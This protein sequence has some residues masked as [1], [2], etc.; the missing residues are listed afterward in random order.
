LTAVLTEL[1]RVERTLRE[2]E[3]LDRAILRCFKRRHRAMY[4]VDIAAAV[5]ARIPLVASRLRAL[6]RRGLLTSVVVSV[7]GPT[8]KV[9]ERRYYRLAEGA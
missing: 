9:T 3:Q 5:K 4:S 6:Q 1:E 8:P 2:R 7:H